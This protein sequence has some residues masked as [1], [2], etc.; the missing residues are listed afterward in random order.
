V[1][2]IDEEAWSKKLLNFGSEK[3]YPLLKDI[4]VLAKYWKFKGLQTH[5]IRLE[6]EKYCLKTDP[7]FNFA[8]SGWKIRKA[9]NA[10]KIYKL[11]TT[12]PVT[13]TKAEVENIKKFDNYT[14][15]KILFVLLVYAKFLK[16]SNTRI[17]PTKKSRVINQFYVN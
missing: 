6:L 7:N 14:H 15:Q 8:I 11:R 13:I 1:I 10:T 16:Y 3:P 9:L 2:I 17:V 12:F 4:I 5:D